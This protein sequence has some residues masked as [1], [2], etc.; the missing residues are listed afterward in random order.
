[1]KATKYKLATYAS[2][3]VVALGGLLALRAIQADR[4]KR[5]RE[6]RALTRALDKT[7]RERT[8]RVF[9]SIV[10]HRWDRDKNRCLASLEYHY[11][12]CDAKT[13]TKTPAQC[14]GPDADIAIYSFLDGG[15]RPL[16][17]CERFYETGEAS[18][19]QSVYGT[20]GTLITTQDIPPDQFPMVKA[21]LLGT[22]P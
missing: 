20:D 13:R 12:P 15:A 19:A 14:G 4:A 17:V 2:V 22:K 10:E 16:L 8:P 18:C 21:G 1:M 5:D 3:A 6:C 9:E 7:I 11:K